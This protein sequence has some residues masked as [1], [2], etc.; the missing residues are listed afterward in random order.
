[1]DA[2]ELQT[3]CAEVDQQADFHIVRF[4]VVDGLGKVDIFQL[5]DGFELDHDQFFD[6]EVYAG[7]R[8][9]DER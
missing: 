8:M 5:D 3:L 6:E 4:E 7:E 9:K 2:L 1:M